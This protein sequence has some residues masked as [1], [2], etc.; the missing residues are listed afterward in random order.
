M[1]EWCMNEVYMARPP[2]IVIVLS[3]LPNWNKIVN[4]SIKGW[5]KNNPHESHMWDFS[6]VITRGGGFLVGHRFCHLLGYQI[7]L[8]LQMLSKVIHNP[9]QAHIWDCSG[10]ITGSVGFEGEGDTQILPEEQHPY[11]AH[12]PIGCCPAILIIKIDNNDWLKNT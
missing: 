9:H 7:L 8:I 12:I 10:V 3:V 5:T 4:Q 11:F 2:K 6:E 1:Y